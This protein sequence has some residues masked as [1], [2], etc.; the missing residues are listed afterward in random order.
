MYLARARRAL[1]NEQYAEADREFRRALARDRKHV[2]ALTGRALALERAGRV[3]A[4]ALAAKRAI[5]AA[6]DDARLQLR[7]GQLLARQKRTHAAG[8]ATLRAA[9]RLDPGNAAAGAALGKVVA[10]SGRPAEAFETLRDA[11][12]HAPRNAKLRIQLAR[13]LEESHHLA[14]AAEEYRA[15]LS[16][17]PENR[18]AREGVL[19]VRDPQSIFALFDRLA[20]DP[21]DVVAA[22]QLCTELAISPELVA[23]FARFAQRPSPENIADIAATPLDEELLRSAVRAAERQQILQQTGNVAPIERLQFASPYT[24]PLGARK[25]HE[26]WSPVQWLSAYVLRKTRPVRRAAVVVT[27]RDQGLYVLEWVAHYRTL[28]FDTIFVYSNDNVDGSERLLR[29]LAE[30]GVIVFIESRLDET[31]HYSPQLKAY[32]H[33]LHLLPELWEHQWALFVDGDELLVLADFYDCSIAKFIADATSRFPGHPPSAI[34]LHWLKY[35]SGDCYSYEPRPLLRRFRHGDL[36]QGVKS[37]VRLRDTW[38]MFQMHVPKMAAGAFAV[39]SDFTVLEHFRWRGLEPIAGKAH[40]NHYWSMSFEEFSLK[41]ARGDS[42]SDRAKGYACRF[43][44]FF[45]NNAPETPENLAPPPETLVV[46]VETE[47]ARLLTLPGVGDCVNAIHGNLATLLT[48]FDSQGG[49]RALYQ[50][51]KAGA[52]RRPVRAGKP[53]RNR[54]TP[55]V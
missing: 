51:A 3:A 19:R 47:I 50:E 7:L 4:A 6:P 28:G 35:V 52:R 30:Q 15:A 9:V 34:C 24:D 36:R 41:K 17:E 2:G 16:L 21:A 32:G 10:R 45:G 43:T 33:A 53:Q 12:A 42:A 40:L 25:S 23:G 49:L 5:A 38:S 11:I 14:E 48:R 20:A 18:G 31:Q 8:E 27:L 55:S 26:A 39:R 37:L 54:V 46:A 1:K 22:D 44:A 13:L 29:I